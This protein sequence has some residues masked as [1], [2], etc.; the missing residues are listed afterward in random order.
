MEKERFWSQKTRKRIQM[1]NLKFGEMKIESFWSIF[2]INWR[3]EKWNYNWVS[4]LLELTKSSW[5]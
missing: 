4:K 5:L 1:N 3:R 2:K